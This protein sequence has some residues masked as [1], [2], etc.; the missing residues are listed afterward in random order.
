MSLCLSAAGRAVVL[1][2]KLPAASCPFGLPSLTSPRL[3]ALRA[4]LALGRWPKSEPPRA[5]LG[6][7]AA[8]LPCGVIARAGRCSVFRDRRRQNRRLY[9]CASPYKG[10][11]SPGT[12]PVPAL[13][14]GLRLLFPP[15]SG[16]RYMIQIGTATEL[17]EDG[18][19]TGEPA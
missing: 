19:K 6:A 12:H 8:R 11:A 17:T 2:N 16:R 18:G 14:F 15:L 5:R 3:P 9:H 7:L 1:R 10:F 13:R 4:A